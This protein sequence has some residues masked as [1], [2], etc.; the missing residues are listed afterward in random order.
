MSGVSIKNLSLPQTLPSN[1]VGSTLIP[2]IVIAFAAWDLQAP[3]VARRPR[4]PFYRKE[5]QFRA[6][7]HLI[8]GLRISSCFL[9]PRALLHLQHNCFRGL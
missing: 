4:Q 5:Q 3:L 9:M 8:A 7:S 1:F 6:D 2:S